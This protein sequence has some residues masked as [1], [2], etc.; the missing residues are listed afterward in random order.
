MPSKSGLF[1]AV[2]WAYAFICALVGLVTT[3]LDFAERG[4]RGGSKILS[5][6]RCY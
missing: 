1:A 5:D 2:R 6:A 3:L 4:T